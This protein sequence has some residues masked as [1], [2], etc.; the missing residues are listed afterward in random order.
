MTYRVILDWVRA[1]FLSIVFFI[2]FGV[3]FY[4]HEYIL[5]D[6]IKN[7]F[8]FVVFLFV[9]SI[10]FLIVSPRLISL[11]LGWDG[12]GLVSYLL[13][14]Y[15]QTFKSYS[16]GIL[17]C[18][19]NRIGD[20]AILIRMGVMMRMGSLDFIFYYEMPI[21][22]TLTGFM[23]LAAITK[24]AQI[25]FSA[26]LPA[27][28]AAPTP[29]SALVHSSTLVTAGVFLIIR[30]YPFL[31]L[32]WIKDILLVRASLTL[33]M[34]SLGAFYETDLKKII[35]LSTLRQ[36]GL[37]ILSLRMGIYLLSFLHLLAHALFKASLFLGAGSIIHLYR[38]RQDIRHLRAVSV[39]IP[40]TSSCIFVCSCALRGFPFL[41]AFYSKDK[42]IEEVLS[43]G[44]NLFRV[45]I[46]FCSIFL[47][48]FY[49][50]RLIKFVFGRSFEIRIENNLDR[51][52]IVTPVILLTFGGII[53]GRFIR[54]ILL[55]VSYD[56]LSVFIKVGIIIL[57]TAGVVMG[58]AVN[59]RQQ[60][61]FSYYLGIMWFLP[62]TRTKILSSRML[63]IGN[64]VF[65]YWDSGWNEIV[66]PKGVS[67]EVRH[68]GAKVDYYRRLPF[69]IVIYIILVGVIALIL[70][71]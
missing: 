46:L 68:L 67:Q 55:D 1:R 34:S 17:T 6:L 27:A 11:I 7:A 33:I 24:R 47:T 38:G 69:K 62:R 64:R 52:L 53:G 31:E 2:S 16:A 28:I 37:I 51:G 60:R 41:A 63:N 3:M 57:L 49:R 14:I 48:A 29:V 36:L 25:P 18:L 22:S 13:V 30:F 23:V 65:K 54:W 19:R 26:W 9:L 8:A 5:H 66:G 50:V 21:L 15:Y 56:N 42:I 43:E 61:N 10:I 39:Y 45:T 70:Y 12:L 4:S 32:T 58:L 44:H 35:A 40:L 71:I 20:R 59:M